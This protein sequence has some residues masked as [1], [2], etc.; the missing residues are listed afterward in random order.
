VS[1]AAEQDW[2]RQMLSSVAA[3]Q[4]VVPPKTEPS[5]PVCSK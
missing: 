5:A 3:E 1:S 2:V 4:T